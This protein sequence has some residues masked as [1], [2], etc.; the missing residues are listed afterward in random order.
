MN[1]W[2]ALL[3]PA[4]MQG[5]RAT[6]LNLAPFQFAGLLGSEAMAIGHHDQA[7]VPKSPAAL[8]GLLDQLFDLGRRQ[9]FAAAYIG[10]RLPG[11]HT[12]LNLPVFV[13]WIDQLQVRNHWR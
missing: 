7:G 6:E 1:R 10:I 5:G 13:T 3:R 2:L 8:L 9:V 11:R 12:L 4:D